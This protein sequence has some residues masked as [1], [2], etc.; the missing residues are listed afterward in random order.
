MSKRTCAKTPYG[1]ELPMPSR[2]TATVVILAVFVMLGVGSVSAQPA[3]KIGEINPF[4]GNGA[5]VTEPVRLGVEM[6][7]EEV[8]GRGGV[9]GRKVEVLFR[10]DKGQPAEAVKH[11]QELVASEKVS[12]IAGTFLSNV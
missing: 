10:D 7:G 5:P 11:A 12:L 6:G 3:I 1:K 8:D 2:R 4:R 9:L